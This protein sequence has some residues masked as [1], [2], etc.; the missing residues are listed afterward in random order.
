MWLV[1]RRVLEI[2]LARLSLGLLIASS[3]LAVADVSHA[4][5]RDL[6]LRFRPSP[7]AI[8]YRVHVGIAPGGYI[9][10]D[11]FRPSDPSSRAEMVR[12][13]SGLP[14]DLAVYVAI[15]AVGP[16]GQQS[17]FSREIVVPAS[18]P[19]G[20][21][22]FDTQCFNGR[23]VSCVN[24]R[25][26]NAKPLAIDAFASDLAAPQPPGKRVLFGVQGKGGTGRYEF[27]WYHRVN[28]GDWVRDRDF[29]AAQ[30]MAL[31]MPDERGL[32]EIAVMVRN[33]DDESSAAPQTVQIYPYR[34]E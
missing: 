13:V 27:A 1:A 7:G 5:L 16:T 21:C 28:G 15:T 8:A 4:A 9:R 12:R 11:E 26:G 6:Q 24:G 34:V 25:C 2:R 20:M 33:E 18:K 22:F 23:Q 32:V 30:F 29:S 17:N 14:D 31:Q 19:G 3:V 10:V